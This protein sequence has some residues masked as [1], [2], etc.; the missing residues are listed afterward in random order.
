MFLLLFLSSS[1]FVLPPSTY[2]CMYIYGD[3]FQS[4]SRGKLYL[5]YVF[6]SP[7]KKQPK[8]K[9]KRKEYVRF[10]AD[11]WP[12]GQIRMIAGGWRFRDS[13]FIRLLGSLAHKLTVCV[14]LSLPSPSNLIYSHYALQLQSHSYAVSFALQP[15]II[16]LQ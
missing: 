14:C 4:V 11:H 15:G 3:V 8:N 5:F 2:I 6:I 10:F 16:H 7:K 1:W 13:V 9:W 12:F